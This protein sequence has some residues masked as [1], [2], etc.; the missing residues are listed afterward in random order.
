MELASGNVKFRI[1]ENVSNKTGKPYKCIKLSFG[2]YE[3]RTPV[4]ITD[5]QFQLIKLNLE[6]K[7]V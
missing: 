4:F 2:S 5:D 7:S 6:K 3:L 1:E